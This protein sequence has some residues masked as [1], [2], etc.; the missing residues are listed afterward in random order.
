MNTTIQASLVVGCLLIGAAGCGPAEELDESL[1]SQSE[2]LVGNINLG[3]YRDGQ[4][5][6]DTGD[7]VFGPSDVELPGPGLSFG[8]SQDRPLVGYG[9]G[10]DCGQASFVHIG[11]FRP[12]N[13]EY[14]FDMNDNFVFDAGDKQ[15]FFA[16]SFV[17]SGLTVLPF[18]W[19]R[20][21]GTTCQGLAGFAVLFPGGDDL[22]WFVDLNDNGVVSG[23]EHL[24]I[25]GSNNPAFYYPV[26]IWSP[27]H[28]SSVMAVFDHN[29]GA[30]FVDTNNN[31]AFDGCATDSCTHFGQSGDFP[32]ANSGSRIR[33]VTR[34]NN[35]RYIDGNNTGYWEGAPGDAGYPWRPL[36]LWAFIWA[37]G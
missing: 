5:Y 29:S 15:T 26:P 20:K 8:E 31:K 3:S 22:F 7:G 12:S 28:N 13:G 1:G 18:I 17:N 23:D 24:G 35:N 10:H 11:V 9:T 37:G 2:E 25:F 30:W 16:S 27:A 32:F 14:F 34:F 36:D 19:T 4:W 33:G 6:L 21:V